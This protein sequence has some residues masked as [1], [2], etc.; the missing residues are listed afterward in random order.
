[1]HTYGYAHGNTLTYDLQQTETPTKIHSAQHK[2]IGQSQ[3]PRP[4]WPID[5][6]PKNDK[7]TWSFKTSRLSFGCRTCA[8]SRDS[9]K[10]KRQKKQD[11]CGS[12]QL[13]G[14]NCTNKKS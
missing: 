11:L 3:E 9:I 14:I 7:I 13:E 2:R 10:K 8:P 12:V 1:M 4:E 5:V 6:A